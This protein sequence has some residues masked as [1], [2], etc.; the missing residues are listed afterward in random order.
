MDFTV[1]GYLNWELK[2]GGSEIAVT[3]ENLDEYINLLVQHHLETGIK[4]Q[5]NALREGFD[6]VFPMDHLSVFNLS[7]L[8]SLL[9]GP[10]DSPW[11]IQ[12]LFF[13]FFINC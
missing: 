2:P 3:I 5:L 9:C 12:S 10:D 13:F 6:S 7:E 1:P 11:E 8:E 4:Y